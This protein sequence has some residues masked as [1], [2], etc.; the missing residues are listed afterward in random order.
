MSA[1]SH[2]EKGDGSG[3]PNHLTMNDIDSYA[4]YCSIIDAYE[5]MSAPKTYRYPLNTFEIIANFEKD[6]NTKYNQFKLNSILYQIAKTQMGLHAKLNDGREGEVILINQTRISRP[7]IKT[8][9]GELID[10]SVLPE[11]IVIYALY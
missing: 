3:Y 9:N 4:Q 8:V 5:A 11:S 2:H 7:M 10:L 1:L 6:G